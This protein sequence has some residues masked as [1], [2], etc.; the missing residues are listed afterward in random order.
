MEGGEGRIVKKGMLVFMAFFMWLAL[1][2]SA[3][4]SHALSLSLSNSTATIDY[5]LTSSG[6]IQ[7]KWQTSESWAKAWDDWAYDYGFDSKG[8]WGDTSASASVTNATADAS[9]TDTILYEEVWTR[10][11]GPYGAEAWA[12]AMR[13]G[14]FKALQTGYLTISVDYL[15]TQDLSTE[16]LGESAEC[17]AHAYLS[18]YNRTTKNWEGDNVTL[19]NEV[20]DGDSGLWEDS[21]TFTATLLFNTGDEVNFNIGVVNDADVYSPVPE[22]ATMLLLGTGL[23]GLGW[24]GRRKVRRLED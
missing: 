21:G 17:K 4:S 19:W 3:D 23:I 18:L 11:T 20:Y 7:W 12:R 14:G 13:S 8:E 22:P 2:F 6:N 5:T 10:S 1:M 9:T 16:Y 24:V 15:L